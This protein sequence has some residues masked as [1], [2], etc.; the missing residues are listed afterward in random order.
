MSSQPNVPTAAITPANG[1]QKRPLPYAPGV[2]Y[3]TST[4]KR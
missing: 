3:S 1:G 4:P 2:I